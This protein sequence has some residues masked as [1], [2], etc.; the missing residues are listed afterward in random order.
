MWDK[1]ESVVRR[2]ENL[3]QELA[4]PSADYQRYAALGKERAELEPLVRAYRAWRQ[5]E[6]Q[7]SQ[8]RDLLASDD[9][10]VRALADAE[11]ADLTRRRDDLE[12]EI[13]NLLL[14][15]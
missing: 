4:A 8:A 1:L 14:P 6:E 3:E 5:V 11:L 9:A 7:T 15:K 12:L 13:R 2:Y 10:D